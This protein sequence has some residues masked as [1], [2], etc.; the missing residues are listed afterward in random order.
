MIRVPISLFAFVAL[1]MVFTYTAVAICY[2]DDDTNYLAQ[3][4]YSGYDP[5]INYN[6]SFSEWL[7]YQIVIAYNSLVEDK[8]GDIE[9]PMFSRVTYDFI[10]EDW[11]ASKNPVWRFTHDYHYDDMFDEFNLIERGG[12]GCGLLWYNSEYTKQ[13]EYPNLFEINVIPRVEI[14]NAY[15]EWV[16]YRQTGVKDLGFIE[17]AFQFF[18]SLGEGF[19]Q[20]MRLLTFSTIPHLPPILHML[21]NLFFIPLWIVLVI[22]IAP[23]LAKF[24]E[25]IGSVLPFT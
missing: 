23:I 2:P 20:M 25:A 4:N 9:Q 10:K 21:L 12:R 5:D 13:I 11:E 1:I 7:D 14:R 8:H 17:A 15:N 16:S 3:S 22:G 24:I 19:V 18:G 6:I